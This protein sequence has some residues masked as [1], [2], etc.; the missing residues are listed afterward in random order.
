MKVVQ[1]EYYRLKKE[2]ELL[3]RK[4]NLLANA[5]ELKLTYQEWLKRK[6]GTNK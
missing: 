3:E 1:L 5:R 4:F 6:T 2:I